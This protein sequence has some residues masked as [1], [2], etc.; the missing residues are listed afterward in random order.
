MERESLARLKRD[1]RSAVVVLCTIAAGLLSV[2][3]W[4]LFLSDDAVSLTRSKAVYWALMAPFA[5][6]AVELAAYSRWPLRW[7]RT[8]QA[9]A[10]IVCGAGWIAAAIIGSP[11]TAVS[12][13]LFGA[14]VLATVVGA[15]AYHG[16]LL[17][18]LR[19]TL[20]EARRSSA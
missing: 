16:S 19:G 12:A 8:A 9:T 15:F 3:V 5:Y 10:P 20:I 2:V 18:N 17:Q 1:R 11:A 13:A 4:I 7:F 6:W 14:C